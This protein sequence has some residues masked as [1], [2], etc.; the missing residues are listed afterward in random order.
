[1]KSTIFSPKFIFVS[2][3]IFIAAVSRFFPHLPNFTP[4]AAIALFGGAYLTD[5]KLAF[6]IPFLAM[7]LSDIFLGFS[8]SSFPVYTCFALTVFIGFRLQNKV[9]ALSVA[10][11]SLVSSVV[12]FMVTNLPVWY[13][14]LALYPN[15][16]Q[17][18]MMSYESA[19]PFFRYSAAGDLFY[20]ALLFSTFY[21]AQKSIP[22]LSKSYSK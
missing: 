6:I 11:A 20:S 2:I 15:T 17:G 10:G 19:L 3:A 5:K 7:F 14:A 18:T 9:T 12:F 8:E 1:M 16:F 13:T 4:I 22:S 21:L